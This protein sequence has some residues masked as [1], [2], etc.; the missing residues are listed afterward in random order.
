MLTAAVLDQGTTTKTAF[1]VAD[2]IDSIGGGTLWRDVLR[3]QPG[4]L[5]T[6]RREAAM[7]GSAGSVPI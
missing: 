7:V 4:S 1:Q 5:R 6:R 2:T 3:R